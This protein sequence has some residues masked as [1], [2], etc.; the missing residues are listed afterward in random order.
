MLPNY[1]GEVFVEGIGNGLPSWGV[2]V[3]DVNIRSLGVNSVAG[4]GE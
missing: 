3:H 4:I 1:V 2:V